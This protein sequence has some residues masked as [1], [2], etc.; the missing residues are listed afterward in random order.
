M[1]KTSFRAVSGVAI[2]AAH[3]VTDVTQGITSHS[4]SLFNLE[5]KYM[6]DP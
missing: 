2:E 4:N 5:N 1:V 3:A 6:K